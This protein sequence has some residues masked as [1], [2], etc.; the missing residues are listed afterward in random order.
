M[1]RFQFRLDPALRLRKF[2][3]EE[4][5]LV[6]AAAQRTLAEE[7]ERARQLRTELDTHRNWRANAQAELLDAQVLAD[8]ARFEVDLIERIAAQN[9]V[10]HTTAMVVDEKTEVVHQRHAETE[11]LER[12]KD[13]RK[14]EH[15]QE[16]LAQEQKALDEHS[17]TRWKRS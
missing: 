14:A 9:R 7:E 2:R 4:A 6:L 8:G 5:Q 17:V 12:L 13:R 11:A 1:R 16:A 15:F 3:L 10:V